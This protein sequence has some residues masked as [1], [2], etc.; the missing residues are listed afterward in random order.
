MSLNF[1]T[2]L[3]PHDSFGSSRSALEYG[4]YSPDRI[5]YHALFSATNFE[6]SALLTQ[7]VRPCRTY[8]L[9]SFLR[10]MQQDEE[11]VEDIEQG[12][13]GNVLELKSLPHLAES[14]NEEAAKKEASSTV[15]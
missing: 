9:S 14:T 5:G 8:F 4:R 10:K 6:H 3:R 1:R 7:E 12:R 11:E 2:R 13:E 15:A